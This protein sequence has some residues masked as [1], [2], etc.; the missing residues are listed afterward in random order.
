M[1]S[2][3]IPYQVGIMSRSYHLSISD[4]NGSEG[5]KLSVKVSALL[6][7]VQQKSIGLSINPYPIQNKIQQLI[8]VNIFLFIAGKYHVLN[9]L[10]CLT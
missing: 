10:R 2:F 4:K 1:K 3:P 7:S 5:T 9:F 6:N 8:E